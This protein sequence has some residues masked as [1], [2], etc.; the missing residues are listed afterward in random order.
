LLDEIG[1]IPASLQVKL[2]RVLQE[3]EYEPP[4]TTRPVKADVRILAATNKNLAELMKK[5]LFR[6]DL[7]YRINVLTLVLPPLTERAEDIPLLVEYLIGRFNVLKGKDVVGVSEEALAILMAHDFPGNVR[8]LEN[9]IEHA[10]ILIKGG[11]IRPRH[12]PGYLQNVN[13]GQNGFP[14]APGPGQRP[15]L[16]EMETRLIGEALLRNNFKRLAAARELGIDKTTLWRKIKRYGIK[17]PGSHS[18]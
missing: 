2:L 8:E 10:L 14:D 16:A 4:G 13:G 3:K 12:L 17:I 7:Y 1:D 15:T 5:G 18:K 11:L 9:I 6:R